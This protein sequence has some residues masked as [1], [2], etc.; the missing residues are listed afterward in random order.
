VNNWQAFAPEPR[1][2]G[3]G[4]EPAAGVPEGPLDGEPA[5]RAGEPPAEAA[6]EIPAEDL[7]S[8]AGERARV[9]SLLGFLA[10]Y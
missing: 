5:H 9:L 7:P 10:D 6:G 8:E 1:G 4:P 2:S 3:E